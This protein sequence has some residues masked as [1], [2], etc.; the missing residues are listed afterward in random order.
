MN[1]NA[2]FDFNNQEDFMKRL[3]MKNNDLDAELDA[4]ESEIPEL[5]VKKNNNKVKDNNDCKYNTYN[6]YFICFI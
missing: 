4:L 6:I 3:Q 1:V 2:N 5:H